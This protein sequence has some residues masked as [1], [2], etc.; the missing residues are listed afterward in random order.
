MTHEGGRGR[1]RGATAGLGGPFI[2]G[3]HANRPPPPPHTHTRR[4]ARRLQVAK[5]TKGE[6][7]M[8]N[9]GSTSVGGRVVSV[10]DAVCHLSL[11]LPVCTQEDEKV[12]L[13]RRVEGHWR[14]VQRRVARAR[15]PCARDF[16]AR[17][18]PFSQRARAPRAPFSFIARPM[19]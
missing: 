17:N 10:G 1:G 6:M 9:I 11:T 13:S 14:C 5:L 19:I 15:L 16:L 2:G 8:V 18:P 4:A 7:L 3:A 12:A